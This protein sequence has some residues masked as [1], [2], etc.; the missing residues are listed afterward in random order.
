[1]T[2]FCTDVNIF[3]IF[4]FMSKSVL[5]IGA[6]LIDEL[7]FCESTIVAH[8]SNPAQKT[9][10]IG[11][12]IS[13]IVQHLALLEVNV[14]L[15]TALGSDGDASFISNTLKNKGINLQESIVVDDCTGK[16]V[17]ILN[18]DGNLFVSACQDISPKYITIPF[19]ESKADYIINFDIIVIDTNVDSKTI[20][21]I[22][23]F[24]RLHQKL[25]IIEPVSVPKASKLSNLNLDGVYMITPN[26]EELLAIASIENQ[27]EKEHIKSLLERGVAKIWLRKGNQG[28]VLYESN[29]LTTLSVPSITIVDSTG[30][31]DAAL[32]GW[33]FGYIRD[34]DEITS[35]Q[36]GHSLALEVLKIKGAVESNM[37]REKL[38]QV[39]NTHY[40]E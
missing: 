32:A 11:G 17:S 38:Y 25:L 6:T 10:S 8:S 27:T 24:S 22:I 19:L 26:E 21:W 3:N 2:R 29:Q 37:N 30:A 33:I 15:I 23:D 35:M 18:S 1:M 12:V 5:C 7:Y 4:V 14:S 13:N 39:K 40:H 31:G 28:S 20:Q 16:Y 34:E 36:L 9:T